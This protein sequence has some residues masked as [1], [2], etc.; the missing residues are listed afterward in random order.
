MKKKE[1]GQETPHKP[2]AQ[3]EKK[4]GGEQAIELR[5]AAGQKKKNKPPKKTF[6]KQNDRAKEQPETVS[7]TNL[8]YLRQQAEKLAK[9]AAEAREELSRDETA[10]LIHELQVHQI[11]LELQ[12]KELRYTQAELAETARKYS[13]L[14]DFAPT[15]YLAVNRT[16]KIL[17]ANLRAAA[18]LG[19]KR[20]L[21]LGYYFPLRI[22]EEEDR[23]NFS[24][25]LHSLDQTEWQGEIV[26]LDGQALGRIMLVNV[27]F[28]ED[29][30]GQEV[31]RLAL[32]DITALKQAQEALRQ[33]RDELEERVKARTEELKAVVENLRIENAERQR[34]QE[35]LLFQSQLLDMVT[36]SV[37]AMDPEGNIL[38]VNEA[39]CLNHGYS[40]E[41]LLQ[42]KIFEIAAPGQYQEKSRE[43]LEQMQAGHP[44]VFFEGVNQR[45][46]GSTY[47]VEVRGKLAHV[48]GRALYLGA[49]RDITERKAAE[50]ALQQLN[51]ELEERVAR[52]TTELRETVAQLGEE[53]AQRQ[54]AEARISA[55]FEA[56][57][58]LYEI[59]MQLIQ[60][61]ELPSLL[62]KILGAA[63]AITKAAKGNVQL[64]D[65]ATGTLQIFRQIGFSQPFLDFFTAVPEGLGTC[66]TAMAQNSRLI[67]KDVRQSAIFAGT[68]ALEVLLAEGVRAVQS[69]PIISRN[70]TLLGMISTHW[71]QPQEPAEH[72]LRLVDL[73]ARQAAELI[74]R[75]RAEAALRASE[76]RFRSSFDQSPVGMVIAD[77]DFK[78]KQVNPAYCRISGYTAT[79][80]SSMA[81]TDIIHPDD[82]LKSLEEMRRFT[83]GE[84]DTVRAEERNIR[85]DGAIIWVEASANL[86]RDAEAHP[87]YYLGIIQDVT[88]RKQAEAALRESEQRLRHLTSQILTTQEQERLRIARDLHDEMGQSLMALKMQLNSFKRRVK[89]GQGDWEELDQAT[90][91]VNLIA[92]QIREICQSLRPA[93][94]ENLGLNGALRELLTEFHKHHGLEVTEEFADLSGL[95]S[96]EA[97]IT[98]YRLFQECL[99][100]AVRHGKATRV[101]VRSQKGDGTVCFSCADNGVG[102]DLEEV[103]SRSRRGT[104]L[105]AMEERVRLLQGAFTIASAQGQGTRIDITLPVDTK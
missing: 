81:V 21:L 75:S 22:T 40:R 51:K 92:D 96:N 56:L 86:I 65:P 35:K 63:I 72:V 18:I 8:I 93:A 79:E 68:L 60:E 70:G 32:T 105:A 2:E 47:P 91:F 34:A 84:I 102:F 25:V 89:R 88:A 103:R 78:F 57:G 36:D 30:E 42:K 17:E 15:G 23:K 44:P 14:Y 3:K 39:A 69:T 64:L 87:L 37:I 90:A 53:V 5:E 27:L 85:R 52:R 76:A 104:G 7:H 100:N 54:Q 74:E 83:S 61:D 48:H 80:L 66:G 73:L 59:S 1:Q 28:M 58:R 4:R 77:L 49:L 101:T 45:K 6:P 67:V 94:L 82:L 10:R 50:A 41:E 38:Y 12:N 20:D 19:M 98:V 33:A 71:Q 99:T 46:D 26:I 31:R 13:D 24:N 55:D 97:Q 43:R 95:F 29:A 9:D 11:E 62:E 16:G